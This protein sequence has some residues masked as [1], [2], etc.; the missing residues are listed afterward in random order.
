MH[1]AAGVVPFTDASLAPVFSNSALVVTREIEWGT[2]VLGF[3][4]A[5]KCARATARCGFSHT[6]GAA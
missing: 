3:E 6:R 1:H 4:Q 2:I 5:N